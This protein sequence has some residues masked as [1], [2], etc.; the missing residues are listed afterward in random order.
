MFFTKKLS[1]ASIKTLEFG[2]IISEAGLN[3][4]TLSVKDMS[5]RRTVSVCLRTSIVRN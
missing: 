2:G 5:K 1:G 4:F 3:G